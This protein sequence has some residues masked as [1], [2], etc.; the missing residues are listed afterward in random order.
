M[1]LKI[2]LFGRDYRID[3]SEYYQQIVDELQINNIEIVI[4]EAFYELLKDKVSF[5]TP[6]KKFSKFEDLKGVD[7]FFSIG[8]DG[9]ILKSVTLIRNSNIPVLG[10]NLGRLGFLSSVSKEEIRMA[11]DCIITNNYI[12][13]KRALLHL[14][15]QDN[16]FGDLNYALNEVTIQRKDHLSM[17]VIHV[18]VDD[19]LLNTYWSDGLIISTPTGSTAYNLSCQGPILTPDSKNFVLTPIATHN[20]TVRPI[21]IPDNSKIKLKISGRSDE[22]MIGLDS[23]FKSIKSNVELIVYKEKFTINLIKM[24]NSSFFNTIREKLNW[25]LDARN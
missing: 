12:L 4:Y 22:F 24:P 20:L 13:D 8:G 17:I 9:T 1:A 3:Y 16:L 14:E 23:G 7:A 5:K 19:L 18:Y 2:A 15:T 6:P 21:V 10:I 11:I 25:G